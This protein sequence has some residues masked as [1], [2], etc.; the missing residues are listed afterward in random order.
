MPSVTDMATR[1]SGEADLIVRGKRIVTPE[2]ERAAAIHIR[3][4]VIARISGFDDV[5]SAKHA[6]WP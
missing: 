6:I 2:G 3:G 5:S 4:G 1:S